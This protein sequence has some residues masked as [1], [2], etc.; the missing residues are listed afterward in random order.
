ML[1]KLFKSCVAHVDNYVDAQDA[2]RTYF[3]YCLF[4]KLTKFARNGSLLL[5][6]HATIYAR[7][8]MRLV[9]RS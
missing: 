5:T 9:T 4:D 1:T 8:D 2:Q 7:C 3:I 6:N